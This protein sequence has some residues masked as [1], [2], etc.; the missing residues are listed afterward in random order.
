M[1]LKLVKFVR[2]IGIAT[3]A[4]F[5]AIFNLLGKNIISIFYFSQTTSKTPFRVARVAIS[6]LNTKYTEREV[7]E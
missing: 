1:G 7:M 5:F 6:K 3:I 4:T 2:K